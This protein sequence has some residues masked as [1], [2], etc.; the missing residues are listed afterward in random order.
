MPI[1]TLSD[2]EKAGEQ[3]GMV[4]HIVFVILAVSL[5]GEDFRDHGVAATR[6]SEV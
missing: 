1:R 3:G 6:A 5:A 4:G 2:F